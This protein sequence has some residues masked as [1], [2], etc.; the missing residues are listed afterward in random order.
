MVYVLF[1]FCGAVSDG[2]KMIVYVV[3]CPVLGTTASCN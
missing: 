3:S 2:G 1:S